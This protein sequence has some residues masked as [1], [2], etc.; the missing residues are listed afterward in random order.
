MKIKI[1][2]FFMLLPWFL[3]KAQWEPQYS[4]T[5][6]ELNSVYFISESTGWVC[7][8]NG[9]VL[10]TSDGGT[11]WVNIPSWTDLNLVSVFFANDLK[12]WILA[13]SETDYHSEV[14]FTNDGGSSWTTQL[15]IN[16]YSYKLFFIDEFNGW[17]AGKSAIWR[18]TDSGA[19]WTA[20]SSGLP[21]K[22]YTSV[23]F[24]NSQL[25][26]AV[27]ASYSEAI[28]YKSVNGGISWEEMILPENGYMESVFFLDENTGWITCNEL[29]T[30][31]YGI[32]LKTID[33]G[34][35]WNITFE[36]LGYWFKEIFFTD[37]STGWVV[38]AFSEGFA[39]CQTDDG[40]FTWTGSN[41]WI[42]WTNEI[43]VVND[44]GWL[45]GKGG[46]ILH[47]NNLITGDNDNSLE[48]EMSVSI[49]CYP[50]P[51]KSGI[52]IEIK[53]PDQDSHVDIFIY[54]IEGSLVKKLIENKKYHAGKYSIHWDAD[55]QDGLRINP[56][57]YIFKLVVND[58]VQTKRVILM[59]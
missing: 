51:F 57:I 21:D 53:I 30:T 22:Y 1:L 48:K 58:Q 39:V 12:G 5:E 15:T 35:S 50:N 29:Y 38:G 45:V 26:W 54:N 55:N 11:N 9:T 44:F 14:F 42:N 31:P 6:N 19:T 33:G 3:L 41:Y 18:T 7:G 43:Q 37:E 34:N 25:G 16:K 17:I 56:G 46:T 13:R 40:G 27:A 59:P 2:T 52:S 10:Y 24:I 36:D 4:G 32:I 23:H 8:F 47:N 28:A 49:N 20:Q